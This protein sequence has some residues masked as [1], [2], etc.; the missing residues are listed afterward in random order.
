MSVSGIGSDPRSRWP[1]KVTRPGR[2]ASKRPNTW[3]RKTP[4]QQRPAIAIVRRGLPAGKPR[5]RDRPPLIERHTHRP[6]SRE[7][8]R[9]KTGDDDGR[10]NDRWVEAVERRA[11]RPTGKKLR[12]GKSHERR[13]DAGQMSRPGFAK[14]SDRI[15]NVAP[16][17]SAATNDP[18]EAPRLR[19]TPAGRK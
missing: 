14:A 17:K 3:K 4:R 11:N 18:T 5:S 13:R 2:H 15:R 19:Q 16:T 10:W 12:R 9:H 6:K 1:A 7:I 8:H